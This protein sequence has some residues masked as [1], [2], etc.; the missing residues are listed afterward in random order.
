VEYSTNRVLLR[1]RYMK[2]ILNGKN[3][4]ITVKT[5]EQILTLLVEYSTNS[6]ISYVDIFGL[7]PLPIENSLLGK[8][9]IF[10]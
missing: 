9:I 4:S 8:L 6:V 2:E 7:C 1:T 10:A 3:I 5:A